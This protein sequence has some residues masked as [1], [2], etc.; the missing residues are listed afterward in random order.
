MEDTG[1]L[2]RTSFLMDRVMRTVGLSGQ[3]VIPMLSSFAC[4]V[5][6]I[7]ATRVI[8]DR[9]DR[10]ATI[11]AAPFMTCSA[12]LPIYALLIAAFVPDESIGWMNLQGLILFGLYL[13]GILG[14]LGTALMLKSSALKGPKPHFMLAL[15]E[16]RLPNVQT[17]AIKLFDRARIFLKR[18]GTVIFVVAILVWTLAYFPRI[19][20]TE[21]SP[22]SNTSVSTSQSDLSN[23]RAAKQMEQS[24]LGRIGRTIEPVFRPLGWDWRVSSAVIAGFPAREVVV[25][26]MGTIYAVGSDAD[27][28]SLSEKLRSAKWPDG[29]PI[30]TLPMVLGLLVFYA[31]CLQCAATLAT[32][33]RETN[34][35]RWPIFAWIY[36]T[37]IGYTGALIIYQVG[38]LL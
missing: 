32:I 4:A 10:I 21:H 6:S 35:W 36:M 25:A 33:R 3:S 2:A 27:D 16:F 19:D 13:L 22:V 12:R 14:G 7:M 17:V 1:Y 18:A 23:A 9:R 37:G 20:T 26:V 28:Q 11:L 5:P 31:W 38:S 29:R 8:P 24:W 15:P 34:S 30:F